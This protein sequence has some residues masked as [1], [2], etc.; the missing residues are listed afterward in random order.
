MIE[1]K[2]IDLIHSAMLA[3]EWAYAPYSNFAVGAAL[4]SSSGEIYTGCNIESAAYSETIC[5]ERVAFSKAISEGKRDFV[6]I[7]IVG[8]KRG[9]IINQI[10]P[11]CGSCRQVMTE[12]CDPKIFRIILATSNSNWEIYNL[13]Q[14]LP[15]N[16]NVSNV[17]K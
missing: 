6:S 7:A 9:E 10:C 4:L 8:G 3:R 12:F 15:L 11:P 5:A 17:L 13:E 1:H 2:K 14:L 16:F